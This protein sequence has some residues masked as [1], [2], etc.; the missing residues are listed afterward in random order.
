MQKI[1]ARPSLNLPEGGK[2]VGQMR[3][4]FGWDGELPTLHP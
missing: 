4:F 3:C 2:L 1:L